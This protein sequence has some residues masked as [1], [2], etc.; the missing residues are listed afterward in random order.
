MDGRI[1][2][3]DW[4]MPAAN[5][6]A[7]KSAAGRESNPRKRRSNKVQTLFYTRAKLNSVDW[8]LDIY[9]NVAFK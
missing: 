7:V 4:L 2:L 5:F 9:F 1:I 8:L 6:E 3:C